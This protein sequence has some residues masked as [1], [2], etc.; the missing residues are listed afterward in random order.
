MRRAKVRPAHVMRCA[1]YAGD[2]FVWTGIAFIG[3]ALLRGFGLLGHTRMWDSIL[4]VRQTA[5]CFLVVPVLVTY[6]LAVAYGRYLRF[7][8]PWA[9][10]VAS[11]SVVLLAVATALAGVYPQVWKLMP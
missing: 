7:D 8:H 9:T 1:V 6:R 11:Q 10:A 4:E 5:L 3:L 2:P